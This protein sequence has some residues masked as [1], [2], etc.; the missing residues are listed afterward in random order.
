MPRKALK[1]RADGRYACRYKDKYFYGNTSDE[2]Y[3]T[4]DEYNRQIKSGLREDALG[5][6]VVQYA[7]QWI[8]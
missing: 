4:R 3:A 1:R 5:K 6:T 2:A 8:T 7:R